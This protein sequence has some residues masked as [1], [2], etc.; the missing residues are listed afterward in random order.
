MKQ[1]GEC[2]RNTKKKEMSTKKNEKG[3]LQIY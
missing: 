1:Q 2:K 3:K